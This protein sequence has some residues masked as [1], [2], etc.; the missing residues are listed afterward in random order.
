MDQELSIKIS[1]MKARLD[2]VDS[3]IETLQEYRD[4]LQLQIAALQGQ[5]GFVHEFHT[6]AD[7]ESKARRGWPDDPAERS[8]E[9]IRR[10]QVAAAKKRAAAYQSAAKKRWAKMTVKQR[11]EHLAKMVKGRKA[12]DKKAA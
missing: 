9:S 12:A 4:D 3:S 10:H 8:A 1:G 6:K 11:K 5:A 7:A 2:G